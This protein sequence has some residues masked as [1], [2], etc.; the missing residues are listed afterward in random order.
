MVPTTI[1]QNAMAPMAITQ[2]A[3]CGI[4]HLDLGP[5]SL[6]LLGLHVDLREVVLDISAEPG[7]GVAW[8]DYPAR[9]GHEGG[10]VTGGGE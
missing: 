7:P 3:A 1:G 5:L 2:Q 4:L 6:D 8:R 10:A 9:P